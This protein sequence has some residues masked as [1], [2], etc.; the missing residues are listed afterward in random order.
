MR[1]DA[2]RGDA[3]VVLAEMRPIARR[4]AG[5]GNAGLGVDDDGAVE[6]AGGGQRLEREQRRRRIAAGA[7]HEPGAANRVGMPLR[8]PVDHSGRQRGGRRI[9]ALPI[10]VAADAEGARE[11]DHA[12]VALE[13]RRADVRGRRLRQRQKHDVGVG[14]QPIDV[15]RRDRP[16]PDALRAPA[17]AGAR[18]SRPTTSPRS[19]SPQDAA[20]AGGRAPARRSRWRRRPRRG[21][22]GA[23]APVADWVAA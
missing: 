9:P 13:Q 1:E 7:R 8:Q 2:V 20:P 4:L 16:V 5:A 14:G 3:A 6:Q 23:A 19:A 11:I 12:T 21:C 15:E 17:A 10:G 22:A 18:S